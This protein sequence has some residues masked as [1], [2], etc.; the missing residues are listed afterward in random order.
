MFTDV[1]ENEA[2]IKTEARMTKINIQSLTPE[3]QV[4]VALDVAVEVAVNEDVLDAVQALKCVSSQLSKRTWMWG[5][6]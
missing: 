2:R 3:P 1:V 5:S 6:E 4:A